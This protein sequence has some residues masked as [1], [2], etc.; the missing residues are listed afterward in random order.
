MQAVEILKNTKVFENTLLVLWGREVD[1]GEVRKKIVEYQLHKNVILGGFNDRM[2]IFW[3][4]C[5]VNLFLSLMM[6][7]DCLLLRDICMEYH[8]LPLRI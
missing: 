6:G 1:N 7:L 4:F 5:D 3:K 8:A 2:D